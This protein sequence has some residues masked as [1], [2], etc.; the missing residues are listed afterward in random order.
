MKYKA[1]FLNCILMQKK[2]LVN[3]AT[4]ILNREYINTVFVDEDIEQA[5]RVTVEMRP[6]AKK[7]IVI[8][9]LN[10]RPDG[11]YSGRLGE[12]PP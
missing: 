12:K 10:P 8:G 9:N 6:D 3:P 4:A 7:L 1:L 5:L 2:Y 11:R